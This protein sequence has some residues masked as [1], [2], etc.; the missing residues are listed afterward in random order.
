MKL[1]YTYMEG[2]NGWLVGYL[3]LYP[4]YK[5]QG[6]DVEELEIMLADV[7]ALAKEE[8]A[9]LTEERQKKAKQFTGTLEI[10][11]ALV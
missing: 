4:N 8:E 9:R 2:E 7:Y 5:T 3:N 10:Q 11:E 1:E 6:K